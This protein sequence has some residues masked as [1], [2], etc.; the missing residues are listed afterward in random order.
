[1]TL[2]AV[3]GP[4]RQAIAGH[5][6][7]MV[8]RVTSAE[9]VGRAA[10]LAAIRAATKAAAD[11]D[12]RIVLVS[13]DA[14]LGKTRLVQA[15]CAQAVQDRFGAVVGG[16]VQFAEVSLAYAPVVEVL[17]GLRDEL[18]EDPF[19]ELAPP[20]LTALLGG[21]QMAGS[22]QIF[23]PL[24]DFLTRLGRL[25]PWLVVFEDLHWS[26]ASTRDLVAFLG[27]N[28]RRAA[29]TLVLT[30]RSDELHRRHPVRPLLADLERIPETERIALAGLGRADLVELL[31][32]LGRNDIDLATV[33]ALLAR[34]GGNPLYVE[35]LVAAAPSAAALH[36][37][38]PA[39]L[40][41]VVL[42]RVGQLSAASQSVLRQAAVL[43]TELDDRLLA[44]S[45]DLP[46][47]QIAGA[48]REALSA[49]LLV[50]DGGGCRFRHALLAEAL[51]E[52]LLPGERQRVHVA[53]ARALEA[54]EHTPGLPQHMRWA[55]LA[56][57]WNA[58]HDLPR[59]FAASVRA[60]GEGMRVNAPA[61][62]AGHLERALELWDQVPD[63]ASRAGMDR[64]ALLLQAAEADHLS[65]ASPRQLTLVNAAYDAL[66][67]AA[68]PERRALVLEQVAHM[69]WYMNRE[70]EGTAAYER[71]VRLLADRPP[72]PEQA[73]AL[74]ALGQSLMVREHP[75]AE[76]VLLDAIACAE[77]IGEHRAVAHARCSLGVVQAELGRAE[78]GVATMRE[79]L[80][81]SQAHGTSRDIA[82]CHANLVATLQRAGAYDEVVRAGAEGLAYCAQAG[83]LDR[84]GGGITAFRA[85]ALTN[86]GR[87]SEVARVEAELRSRL[88]GAAETSIYLASRRLSRQLWAGEYEAVTPEVNRLLAATADIGEPP[89]RGMVLFRAGELA[90]GQ[91]RWDD[92]RAAFEAGLRA[93]DTTNGQYHVAHGLASALAVE[94]D[95][96][97]AAVGSGAQVDADVNRARAVADELA[98]RV[99]ALRGRVGRSLSALLPEPS[100]WR[101]VAEAEHARVRRLDT[102]DQWQAV[103]GSWDK[104]GMP[105]PAAVARWRAA[106]A[107]LRD[108]GGRATA[109]V[110]AAQALGAAE[111]L[112]AA[113]LADEIRLLERRGRLDLDRARAPR[114][115]PRSDAFAKLGV[116]PREAEVLE[117]LAAG[118]TNRQIA[119]AL[120][121]SEKTASVHVSNLLRKLGVSNRI[122]AAAIAQR[123]GHN[124]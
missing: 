51:Y 102:C 13:G 114:P 1:V 12:S 75:D 115:E 28:L 84:Y 122:D 60:G 88:A 100:G 124:A 65:A 63:A 7:E 31:I 36:S 105:Y 3:L 71:A 103:A 70:A 68:G 27:R 32:G 39:T 79:A 99:E 57:H 40:A 5:T 96:V 111:S 48:L 72:S 80:R 86:A 47:E 61:A 113:R 120:Y 59:A 53:A 22:G 38:L 25:R 87:W 73:S 58:A 112:G 50:L 46:L 33:S 42:A 11:G 109:A 95:R 104:L 91:Q 64:A 108:G 20:V 10:E 106:E 41:D 77:A 16:C 110:C 119:E 26:D 34:T 43:G 78:E 81:L 2:S 23:T 90:G 56:H 45:C 82:R 4:I 92:A 85:A 37:G 21:D 66:G 54:G 9:F 98:L 24:L 67:D 30:Y 49:Q 116:T 18:G 74:A 117:L 69:H 89:L 83:H 15:A 19:L 35:E 101:A 121:I 123:L 6:Q 8:R 55:L 107:A 93:C 52:D 94:A 29:V 17:R 62:A 44:A 97:E 118:R 14:G 76:S